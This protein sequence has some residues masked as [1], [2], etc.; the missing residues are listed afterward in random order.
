MGD[1]ST[2]VASLQDEDGGF[3]DVTVNLTPGAAGIG[4]FSSGARTMQLVDHDADGDLDIAIVIG[5]SFNA[6]GKIQILEQLAPG[7]FA[8]QVSYDAPQGLAGGQ[9]LYLRD[10]DG[11]GELDAL[12]TTT[13]FGTGEVNIVWGGL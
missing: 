7:V 13:G 9:T 1:P 12:M 11:D 3:V 8:D 5:A 2:V 6:P 4:A 10:I